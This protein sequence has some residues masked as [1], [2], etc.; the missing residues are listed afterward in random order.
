VWTLTVQEYLESSRWRR[1]AYRLARNP[2]ILFVI[3]PFFLFVVRHR[4]PAAK[5]SR[6]EQHSVYW[7]NLALLGLAAGLSAI[8]GIK[9]YLVIQLTMIGVAASTG[10]WLFYV[11][12]QFEECIGNVARTGI[13]SRHR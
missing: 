10:V 1:F 7:T 11:Q 5:A 6:R 9:A 8:F 2:V 12:H 13:T 4:F 3:A